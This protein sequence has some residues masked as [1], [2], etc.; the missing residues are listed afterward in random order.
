RDP[1]TA[2]AL[3]S[4]AVE[5]APAS[6]RVWIE[7]IYQD[8]FCSASESIRRQ[9]QARVSEWGNKYRRAASTGGRWM[10]EGVRGIR[11]CADDRP[12]VLIGGGQPAT[13]PAQ[14]AAQ[15]E[16]AGVMGIALKDAS[17]ANTAP[18]R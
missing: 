12:L 6:E 3:I 17:V 14:P 1:P 16:Q 15:P 8:I 11:T 7:D 18:G 4:V 10:V 13:A 9:A 5:N 2:L